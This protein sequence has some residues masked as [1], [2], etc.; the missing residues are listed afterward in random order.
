MPTID[1]GS[2]VGPQGQQGNTGPAGPQGVAGPSL[3][4]ASTQTT[5]TGVLAGDGG[6]VGIRAIDPTPVANS[7]NLVASGGAKTYTDDKV[8]RIPSSGTLTVSAASTAGVIAYS[9]DSRIT[10]DYHLIHWEI[11][12]IR[13]QTSEWT[14]NTTT[15][16]TSGGHK[17]TVSGTC[18][19]ATTI[20]LYLERG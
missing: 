4:S 9:D 12:D 17:L 11:G 2:V 19:A 13:R 5:L 7:T 6:T 10:S 1:L 15:N 18:S 14:V 16:P 20:V 8:I 3:I